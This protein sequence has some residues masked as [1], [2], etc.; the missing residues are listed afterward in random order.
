MNND[1]RTIISALASHGDSGCG[2]ISL[3]L[4][5]GFSQSYLRTFIKEHKKYCLTIEKHKFKINRLPEES[6]SVEEIVA[7]IEQEKTEKQIKNRV[8]KAF[9][10][11]LILGI[12]IPSI[13]DLLSDLYVRLF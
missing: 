13:S 11:G 5:T 1:T 2:L 12:W 10:W 8:A 9:G 4:E 3:S 6:S 7:A